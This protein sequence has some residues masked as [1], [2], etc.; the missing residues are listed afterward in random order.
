LNDGSYY[1]IATVSGPL[2]DLNM[3][4]NTATSA[5]AVDVAAPF[6]ELGGSNLTL[7]G[8]FVEGKTASVAFD[9]T[10]NG[11]MAAKGNIELEFFA[12][13]DDIPADGYSIITLPAV[14][15]NLKPS[16]AK[17]FH[18]KPL[19]PANLNLP[20][21]TYNLLMVYDPADS[22]GSNDTTSSTDNVLAS[23]TPFIVS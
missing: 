13:T 14:A 18:E 16:G 21:G 8:T 22:L 10:N 20:A 1:L 9:L 4:N 7:L 2:H 15:V 23:L 5:T 17:L 12:S 11:N 3:A 19:V 6:I